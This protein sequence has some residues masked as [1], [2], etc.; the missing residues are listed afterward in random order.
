MRRL[1]GPIIPLL[2]FWAVIAMI[3]HRAGVSP[4]MIK[5]G[6]Q[7]ALIPIWFL[8]VYAQVVVLVPVTHWAWRRFGMASFWVLVLGA[9]LVDYARFGGGLAAVGW[10]NYLFIW[11]AV[12]QMGYMWRDGHL[13]GLKKSVPWLVGG[14][15]AMVALVKFAGYPISMVSVPGAEVSNSRPPSLAMLALGMLHGGLV[16]SLEGPA[17][18]LLHRAR[19]WAAT[20]LVNG[21][22]MSVY[23][24][25]MT[26][27]ILLVGL[28]NLLGG[29][30]L[31]I[32]PGTRDW[33]LT[34][35]IWMAA[36]AMVLALFL[37]MFGRF[38]R[39]SE[40]K[41]PIELPLWRV[42]FGSLLVCGALA[43]IAVGGIG[44]VAGEGPLGI[45]IWFVLA[46]LAGAALVGVGPQFGRR[47]VERA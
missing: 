47:T 24:W 8:A 15:V 14:L 35:P 5:Y 41:V 37:M 39:L 22:I 38:E 6:S 20:I 2:L 3:A 36:S 28:L 45:R 31:H 13:G 23:L 42:I 10:L 9:V 26:A 30:G 1:I 16:L 19:V 25:H 4:K 21:T 43:L 40:P 18:R 11:L 12:H 32:Q 29:I 17:R 33:W 44:G 27:V 34:R 46:A 7:A